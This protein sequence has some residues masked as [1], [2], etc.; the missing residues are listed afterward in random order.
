V[1]WELFLKL[2]QA[3][4]L[5]LALLILAHSWARLVRDGSA[6]DGFTRGWTGAIRSGRIA[7]FFTHHSFKAFPPR[8]GISKCCEFATGS[9]FSGS[10]SKIS[11]R[12]K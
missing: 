11:S 4:M 5:G 3:I 6:S 12:G 8:P 7:G 10:L 9:W 1:S 2:F